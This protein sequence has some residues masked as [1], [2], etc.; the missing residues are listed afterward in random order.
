MFSKVEDKRALESEL[1]MRW[2]RLMNSVDGIGNLMADRVHA[3]PLATQVA[4][5]D[6]M[7]RDICELETVAV[8][9]RE[10]LRKEGHG[11]K[12]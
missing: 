1:H 10:L 12:K 11:G 3:R 6:V 4:A 9:Y 5:M 2:R 7:L 8:K